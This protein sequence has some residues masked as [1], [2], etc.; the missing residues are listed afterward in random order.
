MRKFETNESESRAKKKVEAK[1]PSMLS[2]M[3]MVLV[4]SR[5]RLHGREALLLHPCPGVE[6]RLEGEAG[7]AHVHRAEHRHHWSLRALVRPVWRCPGYWSMWPAWCLVSGVRQVGRRLWWPGARCLGGIR[8]VWRVCAVGE[9][10]GCSGSTL[11]SGRSP[12][13]RLPVHLR[14][15][16]AGGPPG[17]RGPPGHPPSPAPIGRGGRGQGQG[18]WRGAGAPWRPDLCTG[19]PR[20]PGGP[21]GSMGTSPDHGPTSSSTQITCIN[22]LITDKLL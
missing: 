12:E 18:W 17:G 11:G 4:Y 9:G 13:D 3:T 20:H 14:P 6:L 19:P 8:R 21:L 22:T 2:M 5:W 1:G 10:G 7:G 16:L 15:L